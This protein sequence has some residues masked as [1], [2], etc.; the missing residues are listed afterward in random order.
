M[1]IT[2]IYATERKKLSTTYNMAQ[3]VINE[4]KENDEVYE[5]FL[6]RDMDH[7]CRG[8][9]T[10]FSGHPEKC[11]GYDKL[12]P[13]KEAMDKSDLIIF[14]VPVYVFHIPGQVKAFLDHFAYRWM[15]HSPNPKMFKKQA[16]LISTA[17]GAGTKSTIRDIK[18]SMDFWGVGRIYTFK[19]AIWNTNW[20]DIDVVK[21]NKMERN[22]LKKC[23]KI[24]KRKGKVTPR[25]KVKGL[26][27][28]SRF[29]I[30]RLGTDSS[31]YNY[32]DKN[33]W[34]Y[35]KRPW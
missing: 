33:N 9:F 20:T 25:L 2:A 14:T 1:I 30:K 19:D 26:F 29:V 10:C 21:Q 18:D 31:D 35:K 4:L 6:P 24:K 27:Y 12:K 3:S 8:C 7:F 22:I 16:M 17:A 23:R 28:F 13:I 34:L 32:W 15:V 5:Y 11:G